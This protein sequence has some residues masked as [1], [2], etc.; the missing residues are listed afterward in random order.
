MYKK[1]E[2][3]K[4]IKYIMEGLDIIITLLK[5]ER[6]EETLKEFKI[7]YLDVMHPQDLF[8][9]STIIDQYI[10]KLESQDDDN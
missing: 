2:T 5:N 3:N 4:L 6:G 9:I 7:K 8:S 10:Y 1:E